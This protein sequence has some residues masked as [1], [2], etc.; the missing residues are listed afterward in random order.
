VPRNNPAPSPDLQRYLNEAPDLCKS[1][2]GETHENNAARSRNAP[3]PTART[4]P[5]SPPRPARACASAAW[6]TCPPPAST[7]K[8]PG[9]KL[10][11]PA[12]PDL[13]RPEKP[14]P[15]EKIMA[16]RTQCRLRP[17]RSLQVTEERRYRLYRIP[18][19]IGQP[20]RQPPATCLLERAGERNSQPRQV[21]SDSPSFST[22][23]H[24]SRGYGEC[25]LTWKNS[26]G[27]SV[28]RQPCHHHLAP[29][30]NQHRR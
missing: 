20:E 27:C 5:R 21:P 6:S 24:R 23:T 18:R 25:S 9:P 3:A 8:G 28:N 14:E 13:D 17:A 7:C 2:P 29:E 26:A 15:A 19:R 1:G 10:A 12:P 11:S 22:L 16:V 30:W 4:A